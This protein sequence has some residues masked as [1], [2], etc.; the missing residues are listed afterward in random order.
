L[1]EADWL[2]IPPDAYDHLAAW[3]GTWPDSDVPL[4][5]EAATY[6]G[7]PVYFEVLPQ[8]LG[9]ATGAPSATGPAIDPAALNF[10]TS[11]NFAIFVGE[12]LLAWRNL[13]LGRGD[14]RGAFRLARYVFLISSLIWVLRAS[15]VGGP[16]EWLVFSAGLAQS[17]QASAWAW[18]SYT[19]FEPFVRRLWPETLISWTR[20]LNGRVR[21]PRVGRDIVLGALAG[22]LADIVVKSGRVVPAWFGLRASLELTPWMYPTDTASLI[23]VVL[24]WLVGS[25]TFGLSLLSMLLLLRIVLR[26]V[27]VAACGFVLLNTVFFCLGEAEPTILTWC[28]V[29]LAVALCVWI[30]V[31]LGLLAT[32]VGLVVHGVLTLPITTDSSAFHFGN[33]LLVMGLVLAIALYGAFTSLGGR[34]LFRNA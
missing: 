15:H 22:V 10:A 30:M 7:R 33:G 34:P 1:R 3:K 6:L 8:A 23:G 16:L 17:L 28:C 9:E 4:Y 13:R 25:L 31:R 11:L 32:V 27:W 5:I 19:A 26:S 14:R 24:E 21:D 12:V 2:R 29:G 20:L 18:L